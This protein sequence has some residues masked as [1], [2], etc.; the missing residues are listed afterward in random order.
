MLTWVDQYLKRLVEPFALD[1]K[2]PRRTMAGVVLALAVSPP[3][4]LQ[5]GSDAVLELSHCM[6]PLVKGFLPTAEIERYASLP[7]MGKVGQG[8]LLRR[9]TVDALIN[10]KP[11]SGDLWFEAI[12]ERMIYL[13]LPEGL[14][15]LSAPQGDALRALFVAIHEG[16]ALIYAISTRPP[17]P[18]LHALGRFGLNRDGSRS[19]PGARVHLG[20]LDPADA[21]LALE[22][23]AD[24]V[25]LTLTY[26]H[27]ADTASRVAVPV[28]TAD[29]VRRRRGKPG[30][31]RSLFA[32]DW[33]LPPADRFGRPP[34][35]H[36]GWSLNERQQV[37]GHFRL[38][39]YGPGNRLRKLVFINS[40]E[41]GPMDGPQR[42]PAVRL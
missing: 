5:P 38:Q 4:P 17:S 16:R 9:P 28:A 30:K 42:P 15:R 33:L 34:V 26:W 19:D 32:I 31:D 2:D 41:R 39:P 29:E 10:A 21:D 7:T 36:D 8:V 23:L 13:D 37:S 3:D 25:R 11:P 24:F 35:N 12:G 20:N 1:P 27:V 18:S 40:Y 22:R 14:I 6:L